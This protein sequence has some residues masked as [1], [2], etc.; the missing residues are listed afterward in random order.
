MRAVWISTVCG[1]LACSPT[2]STT[3][4]ARFA[5]G[6]GGGGAAAAA[7]ASTGSNDARPGPDARAAEADAGGPTV[8]ARASGPD[9]AG[10]PE[11]DAAVAPGPDAALA[12]GVDAA[13]APRVDAAQSPA[14]D[15]GPGVD[16]RC[17]GRAPDP[18]E[19]PAVTRWIA[20]L[21]GTRTS[22][23]AFGV[24]GTDLGI[25]VRQPDG[26]I[27][28][29]FGDTF[30]ED[31][32]GGPG[33]RSPVLLRSPP[34]LGPDG[35]VFT[36]AAGGQYARQ[37]LDYDHADPEFSTWLP[38]DVITLG[39]RMYLHFIVNAGLGN[40]AGHR[41]PTRTT[42]ANTGPSATPAGPPTKMGA[43]DNSGP[44][45]AAATVMCTRSRRASSTAATQSSCTACPRTAC[46]T[47][48][49]TSPGGSATVGGPGVNPR[50]RCSTAGLA[51]SRCAASRKSGC[52]RGSTPR[53]TTSRSKCST[54]R[55]R[56]STRP[57][58][59]KPV[60]GAMLPQLYGG[61]I[62]PDS[63]LANLHLIVSQWNTADGWPYPRDAVGDLGAV[64][65]DCG[66][67]GPL[68][69]RRD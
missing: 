5:D 45:S 37:I 49:P 28:Y 59:Y 15:A 51:S 31:R 6:D 11:A 67:E 7:D 27:A 35:I 55:R 9:A 58:T 26:Q 54:R 62:H 10:T 68:S 25:P 56:T 38:S 48:T 33:W 63:T 16:D 64:R 22:S 18:A 13:L 50:H 52:C 19:R 2:A 1:V 4:Y 23:G 47:A 32:A 29:V 34:G 24:G 8:D 53:T 43:C 3:E 14:P 20:D 65:V 40:V 17:P 61:Y 36:S 39:G 30:E 60:T 42:T 21:T 44:G 46:S 66:D 41:S 12:P 69:G 57:R